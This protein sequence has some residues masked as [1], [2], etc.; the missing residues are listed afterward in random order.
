LYPHLG[1]VPAT[2]EEAMR[3]VTRC[4]R[5]NVGLTVNL[6]HELA[7]GNGARL[8]EIIRRVAPKLE[9]VSINGATDQPGALWKN[10]IQ[11]LGKGDYDVGAVLRALH[12]VNYTGP[13]GLQAYGVAGEPREN[14][15]ASVRAWRSLTA[16]KDP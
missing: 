14:L 8:V 10:Y 7:A 3:L 16:N 9:L 6:S 1:C 4:E 13:V 5:A 2:A 15:A 12:E 11:P